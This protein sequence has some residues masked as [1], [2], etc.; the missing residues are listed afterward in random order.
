MPTTHTLSKRPLRRFWG[1]GNADETLSPA[2]VEAV[3]RRISRLAPSG[4]SWTKP[5]R[6]EEFDLRTPRV[7]PP[8]SLAAILSSSRYDRLTHSYGKSYADCARMWMRHVPN[9]PD[10]VAFPADESQIVAVLDWA[11]S[12]NVAVIPFGGG[13]SVVGGVEPAVGDGYAGTVSLD[14]ERLGRVLEVDKASRAALIEG[15]TYGPDLETQL[16]P[17]G[18][19]LR[20]FPQSFQ[21]S[22]FG[23]WIVTRAGGHFATLYTHIDDL[24]QATRTITP[25]GVIETRRLPGSGAGPAPD[26]LMLGSEG[27]LGVLT[28]AWVR[29]QA[30]P[31]YR[32]SAAAQFGTFAAAAAAVR[33]LSQSG[34]YPANCRL[35]DEHEV[36]AGSVGD[37]R[38]P[39][40]VLGFES[41]DHPV[42]GALARALELV[43]D[44][45]GKV[46]REA[47]RRSLAERGSPAEAEHRKG[48]AGD[49]RQAFIRQPHLR[50]PMVGAGI[51]LDTFETAITWDR[52]EAFVA[53]VKE[54]V[55][56]AIR[57]ATGRGADISCRFT[58]VY[59]DGPAPY[60]T[61]AVLGSEQGD[62]AGALSA[63]REIKLAC[64]EIVTRLG[65]TSTH[66]HAVGRDHRSGYDRET[67]DLFRGA[68]AAAKAHLD[69]QAI[70]NPGVLFDPV[71]RPLGPTGA[72]AR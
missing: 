34:L 23:G 28:R 63:W 19:T 71:G 24:V 66:H 52:A 49:W 2:E 37:G 27:T 18:L 12:A 54:E 33:A 47:A 15:G 32:G 21:F 31:V 40:L 10:W 68:L 53:S 44:H 4:T 51:I 26:R 20:H 50:D 48:A 14:L 35:L 9:P 11:A 67:P 59:P 30:R 46:D 36:A 55:G 38:S 16:R 64:N 6:E 22:T 60:F 25:S 65:G 13:S 17:H 42:D 43:A 56:A 45:G 39:T 61:Y 69:P 70:L 1:W 7:S 62:I 72:L 29:L 57:K 5:P 8:A 58:H 3:A 41:A